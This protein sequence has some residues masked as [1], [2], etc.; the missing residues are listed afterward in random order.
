MYLQSG[1]P[2]APLD[3]TFTKPAERQNQL[4]WLRSYWT[5]LWC[6]WFPVW[7]SCSSLHKEP[8]GKMFSALLEAP[9]AFVLPWL[10]ALLC[11]LLSSSPSSGLHFFCQPNPKCSKALD[12][13][14]H[15]LQESCK[16]S[17]FFFCTDKTGQTWVPSSPWLVLHTE[18]Y[19]TNNPLVNS[20]STAPKINKGHSTTWLET[21]SGQH[22]EH[23]VGERGD[24]WTKDSLPPGSSDPKKL[25]GLL[26]FDEAFPFLT[27][28]GKNVPCGLLLCKNRAFSTRP[29]RLP[30]SRHAFPG[31]TLSNAQAHAI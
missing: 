17:H 23:G 19:A 16:L 11:F 2:W 21:L 4:C 7:G 12:I 27:T 28:V 15:P 20:L 9:T 10:A 24:R 3:C 22:G 31:L 14:Y 26:G 5:W 30:P 1:L 25:A 29:S 8:Q 18:M 6:D 13:F